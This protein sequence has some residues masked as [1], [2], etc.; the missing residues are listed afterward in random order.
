MEKSTFKS[1]NH[2][3]K[4]SNPLKRLVQVD[5]VIHVTKTL[6]ILQK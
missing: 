6:L 3:P 5:I 2:A 4:I 1:T